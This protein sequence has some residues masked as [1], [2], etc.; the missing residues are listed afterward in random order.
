MG[1]NFFLRDHFPCRISNRARLIFVPADRL[2][3]SLPVI[4]PKTEQDKV[5]LEEAKQRY[6]ALLEKRKKSSLT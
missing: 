6:L 3:T 4:I 1:F 5:E 2:A